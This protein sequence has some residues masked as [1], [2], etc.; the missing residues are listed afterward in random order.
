MQ[1]PRG[2][3][4]LAQSLPRLAARLP[5]VPI[6]DFPT[7][8]TA[9]KDARCDLSIKRDDESDSTYGGNKLRKLEYLFGQALRRR[10]RYVATFGA[11]SSN[12]A[13]AT[14]VHA[15]RLGLRPIV[16]LSRQPVTPLLAP[17]LRMHRRLG[18]RVVYWGG[19]PATRRA[20]L[21]STIRGLPDRTWFM[22]SGGSS[23]V[24]A[25]GYINAAFEL[26][27]QIDA[28]LLRQPDKIYLPLGTMGTVAGLAAGLTA[29]GLDCTIVAVRVVP[30][31]VANRQLLNRYVAKIVML[32]NR[33]DARI[34][35]N[36]SL[37]R[38]EFRDEQYGQGYARSTPAADAAVEFAKARWGLDLETTYSGK[39]VAALRADWLS[40]L[41][42]DKQVLFWNTFNS[43]DLKSMPHSGA[44]SGLPL[45]LQHYLD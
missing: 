1:I 27:S 7:R 11:A 2:F 36:E 15:R 9:V 21:R 29:A 5:R 26:R 23:W 24:G 8:V 12:H 3:S 22:P 28:G 14:A 37:R 13:L 35:E 18:S 40:G 20:I 16:F 39:A 17:T 45:E 25:I 43:A 4:Y 38:I 41:L 31:Y 10:A 19:D 34:S 42:D 32:C 30:E 33:L 6:G 44:E